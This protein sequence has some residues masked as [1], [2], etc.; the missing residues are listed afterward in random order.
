MLGQSFVQQGRFH[1]V[2]EHR[3]RK[4]WYKPVG[5]KSMPVSGEKSEGDIV[6]QTERTT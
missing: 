1:R 2:A 3:P 4:A 6:L 5:A